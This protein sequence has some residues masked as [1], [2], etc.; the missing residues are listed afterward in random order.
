MVTGWRYRVASVL[1]VASI[2]LGAVYTAN[3]PVFQI[4]L[5]EYVPVVNRLK[6]AVLEGGDL[7]WALFISTAI[8]VAS[9]TK[10]FRP[11]PQRALDIIFDVEK[12]VVFSVCA[13]A[14]LGYFEWSHRLP[15]QTVIL[16]TVVLGVTLPAFFIA[17]SMS[18]SGRTRRSVIVGNDPEGIDRVVDVYDA[19]LLGYLAP[20]TPYR[21]ESEADE[22]S[23]SGRGSGPSSAT[24]G[25]NARIEVGHIG[26]LSRFEETIQ[27]YDVD[28]AILA[29]DRADRAEFFG[30]LHACHE[31]GV[32]AK[33]HVEHADSLLVDASSGESPIV[34]VNLEPWDLQD[35]VVK[36]L[37]D[38]AF[39]ATALLV[40][41]PIILAIAI[42]IKL[43][44]HGPVLF[45]Q[46]RTYRF[47][48]KFS[49]Y[50]FRTL[51]PKPEEEV[52]LVLTEDRQTPLGNFLRA[53]HLDELP[54]LWS[55]LVG[56][57]SVVGPRPAQSDLEEEFEEE[58]PTW[59]Q[60][61]FVKPGL[62]GLAQINDATGHK[63]KQ[64]VDYDIEYIRQQSFTFDVKIV[65]RQIWKV[66]EDVVTLR[67]EDLEE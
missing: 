42:A 10:L 36:R 57:M 43:E 22:G 33:A 16:T 30:A 7:R 44:G 59:K 4:L 46:N 39:A 51:K 53:T 6:P 3:L 5:T 13:M 17:I 63:P 24:D 1:G 11:R 21:V 41:S 61:W 64:K 29:F 52:G 37:F 8:V 67:R 55:I 60:R 31:H 58:A 38:V 56:D 20:P 65:L 9:F 2:T 45:S 32:D 62:T 28:T 23:S 34:D 18:P 49:I 54:Q 25:G 26:G 27:E 15:R 47:G 35:R 14:T 40:L 50:K 66:V 12:R 48:E 19:P